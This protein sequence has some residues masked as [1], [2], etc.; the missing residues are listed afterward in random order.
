ML[1]HR[2]THLLTHKTKSAHR[3]KLWMYK[4]KAQE[5]A[6]Q[7]FSKRLVEQE[8]MSAGDEVEAVGPYLFEQSIQRR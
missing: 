4:N 6:G 3:N 2:M 7:I 8:M 5:W 1:V